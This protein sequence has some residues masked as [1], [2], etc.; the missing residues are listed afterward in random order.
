MKT[1][2]AH[3]CQPNHSSSPFITRRRISL[4]IY[5]FNIHFDFV[6]IASPSKSLMTT[7]WRL[8]YAAIRSSK[9]HFPSHRFTRF[10]MRIDDSS[11]SNFGLFWAFG[12]LSQ[13]SVRTII[14][15]IF[16]DSALFIIRLFLFSWLILC[17]RLFRH[18]SVLLIIVSIF[19]S[20][21]SAAYRSSYTSRS[22]C[23]FLFLCLLF[24]LALVI[25]S[26]FDYQPLSFSL[27]CTLAFTLSL[28]ILFSLR[29]L[30]Q[31]IAHSDL[32]VY[33]PCT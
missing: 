12:T 25:H 6:L 32:R 4:V 30:V 17:F 9:I 14:H 27:P 1:I 23:L 26:T 11:H 5:V 8:F 16:L 7:K 33:K 10:Q 28:L 15:C 31:T 18:I 22:L 3:I 29:S 2:M 13:H 24:I 21:L 19:A 20:H